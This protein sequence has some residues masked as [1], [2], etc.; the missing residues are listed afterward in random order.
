MMIAV[1]ADDLTGAAEIGGIGLGYNLKVEIASAVDPATTADMLVINTDARSKTEA[2]AIR[3]TRKIS[4]ELKALNPQFIYK[5]ID[6]VM[7]GHVVAEIK[8]QCGAMDLKSALV[9][10]ANPALGR[11][12]VNGHYYINEIPAHETSF[13][14]DPEFPV[15][16]S[17]I[18]TRFEHMDEVITVQPHT[19]VLPHEGIIIGEAQ[20]A[21]DLHEWV[22]HVQPYTL[23]AGASGFF[24]ACLNHLYPNRY[25]ARQQSAV[26]NSPMLYISGS[27]YKPSATLIKTLHQQH[28]PV[29]YMPEVLMNEDA[30]NISHINYWVNEISALL[31]EQGKA[32]IAIPQNEQALI[33]YQ[34]RHLRRQ[35]ARVVKGVF[36][37]TAISEMVIEGGSTAA[38]ILD[39]LDINS[40]FPSQELLPGVIR[41]AAPA[42]YA[43]LHITLKPGSYNWSSEV[44]AF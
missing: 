5:K 27:T 33:K 21:D 18:L 40:I 24:R 8:A 31:N 42:K 20:T 39:E 1:I 12:L 23:A 14:H 34:A 6:S 30:T 35:M 25:A 13:K 44:W 38:A 16:H 43:N 37:Q 32:V 28:G 3:I 10:P 7:R 26:L 11:T 2:E 4:E 29:S 9:I 17:H 22:Q 41:N 36:S 19:A 15:T